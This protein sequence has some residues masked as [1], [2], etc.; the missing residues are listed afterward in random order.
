MPAKASTRYMRFRPVREEVVDAL[1]FL[2]DEE[3]KAI[4]ALPMS[5]A[6]IWSL[7]KQPTSIIETKRLMRQAFP[8]V[9]ARR[10]AHDVDSLFADLLD[11]RLIRAS[12]DAATVSGANA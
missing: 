11:A 12:D 8:E 1:L 9:S 10:I 4:H 3:E 2:V 6:A 7:L 5:S